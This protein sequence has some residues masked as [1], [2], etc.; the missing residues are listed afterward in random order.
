MLWH[1]EMQIQDFKMHFLLFDFVSHEEKFADAFKVLLS[2]E[3]IFFMFSS[4]NCI[5]RICDFSSLDL[6]PKIICELLYVCRHIPL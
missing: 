4:L 5:H 2:S 6:S 3:N 1:K